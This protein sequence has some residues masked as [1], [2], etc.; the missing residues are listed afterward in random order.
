MTDKLRI[1]KGRL[2]LRDDGESP[3]VGLW[4][5]KTEPKTTLAALERAYLDAIDTPVK[6]S[7]RHTELKQSGKYTAAGVTDQLKPTAIET[8]RPLRKAQHAISR[9]RKEVEAR[10]SKM[11]LKEPDASDLKSELQRQE[12]RSWLRS[13]P[14]AERDRIF[15]GGGDRVDPGIAE[16]VLFA[17]PELSGVARSNITLMKD[18]LLEAQ[19]PG[20]SEELAEIEQAIALTERA[21]NVCTDEIVKEIGMTKEQLSKLAEPVVREVDSAESLAKPSSTP[22]ERTINAAALADQIKGL[23]YAERFKFIDLAIDTNAD[24][25]C[26]G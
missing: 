11:K 19:F 12:I 9:A 21:V 15:N 5:W 16:A 20:E 4:E 26:R 22:E 25:L 18:R 6:V 3:I 1:P 2:R 14:Q 13:L 23:P 7:A 17:P 24:E 10:R 8:V